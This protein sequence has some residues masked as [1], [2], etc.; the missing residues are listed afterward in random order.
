MAPTTHAPLLLPAA[1]PSPTHVCPLILPSL[2][3]THVCPS[4]LSF[5]A[6]EYILDTLA[7]FEG[8]RTECIRRLVAGLPLMEG[9]DHQALLAEVRGGPEGGAGG[10]E[11]GEMSG[12]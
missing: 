4:L 2:P 1:S 9:W 10:R 6:E 8:S 11:G 5:V 7:A 12:G 3:H